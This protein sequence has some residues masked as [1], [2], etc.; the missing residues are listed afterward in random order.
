MFPRMMYWGSR[1][2]AALDRQIYSASRALG[3]VEDP[4]A[5]RSLKKRIQMLRDKQQ[6]YSS[7]GRRSFE[8][9]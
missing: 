2:A 8:W 7:K 1:R 4:L 5:K 9:Q 3:V 6:E